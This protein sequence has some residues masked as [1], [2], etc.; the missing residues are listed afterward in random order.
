MSESE[1]MHKDMTDMIEVITTSIE[2][3]AREEDFYRRSAAASGS[4]VARALFLEIADDVQKHVTA[5]QARRRKLCD[6]LRDLE[7]ST[8]TET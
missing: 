5:L 3:N 1:P 7:M 6:A 4:E 2:I 8:K